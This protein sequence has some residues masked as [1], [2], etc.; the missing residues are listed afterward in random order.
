MNINAHL[1]IKGGAYPF[2]KNR[3]DTAAKERWKLA[4]INATKRLLKVRGAC[5][6]DIWFSLP[7]DR[8]PLDFPFGTDLDN[9]SK[10]VLDAM[11]KTVL[12]EAPGKDSC[13][14]SLSTNKTKAKSDGEVG[15]YLS[16]RTLHGFM[17]CSYGK[18]R[19]PQCLAGIRNYKRL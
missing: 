13:V 5:E 1:L 14:V 9:L 11:N 17:H 8:F 19:F 18:H 7:P 10:L 6:V 2:T 4:I 16:I 3:G 15:I 12:S